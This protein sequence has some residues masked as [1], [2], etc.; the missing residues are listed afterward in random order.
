MRYLPLVLLLLWLGL[1]STGCAHA[2]TV[3]FS[4][5]TARIVDQM[6]KV[7]EVHTNAIGYA[8]VE[9]DQ[10]HNFN[11]LAAKAT[12]AELLQLTDHPNGVVR[13]YAFWALS[14]RDTVDHFA[15][16]RKHLQ[17]D[18]QVIYFSGC[19]KSGTAVGDFFVDVVTPNRIDLQSFKVDSAQARLLDSLLVYVP[20]RLEARYWAIQRLPLT[21]QHYARVR[22]LAQ[23]GD[24]A[25]FKRL[26]AYHKE[27][28]VEWML[29]IANQH[30]VTQLAFYQAI[31]IFPHPRFFDL[32]KTDWEE[33]LDAKSW[34]GEWEVMYKAIAAYR[35]T[36]AYD[37]MDRTLSRKAKMPMRD[38]HVRFVFGA[39]E[40]FRDT[41]YDPLLWR[42]WEEENLL[43][44][45]IFEYLYARNPERAYAL[46]ESSLQ[47]AASF[48]SHNLFGS[49]GNVTM[50][51]LPGVLL[52]SVLRHNRELGLQ[53]LHD[54]IKRSNV[55]QFSELA[56]RIVALQD[57]QSVPLLLQR[58]KVEGNPY[59]FL[60][61]AQ[62]LLSFHS[63]QF[64]ADLLHI[65]KENAALRRDWGGERLE[66]L[67]RE[68]GL[69]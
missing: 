58:L 12:T 7:N 8:G 33:S 44:F 1:H 46:T 48:S 55:F 34:S 15:V 40:A 37:L 11:Q 54:G 13:C 14:Y 64:N 39:I 27:A 21:A 56:D 18:A 60:E 67:L 10:W 51:Q 9:S 31:A 6:V 36:A 65:R 45:P 5:A 57:T 17:D 26:A 38:Y 62:A 69:L 35:N 47:G 68:N 43:S 42:L 66:A 23:E 4:Q 50:E 30:K 49:E 3:A 16:V 53:V 28:D 22:E 32:L 24:A 59:V 2:Q 19:I 25:A 52:D 20:N 29:R 41:I 61:I 63:D